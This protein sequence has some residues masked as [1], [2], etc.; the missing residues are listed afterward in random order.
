MGNLSK[1]LDEKFKSII[2]QKSSQYL[3]KT[4]AANKRINSEQLKRHKLTNPG[5]TRQKQTL[6]PPPFINQSD[7]IWAGVD[8]V[9]VE[10]EDED[11]S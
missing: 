11:V 6:T 8:G 3:S 4:S 5:M 2:A 9:V 10:G 1:C 7:Q